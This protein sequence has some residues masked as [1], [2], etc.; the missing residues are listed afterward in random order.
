MIPFADPFFRASFLKNFVMI[1]LLIDQ[2]I[3]SLS[4]DFQDKLIAKI[5]L[6][7]LT[8]KSILPIVRSADSKSSY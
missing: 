1:L 7:P 3:I 2:Q 4:I 6:I 5:V 8:L